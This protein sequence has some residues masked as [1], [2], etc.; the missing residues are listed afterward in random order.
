MS[1]TLKLTNLF[2]K[3]VSF[4]YLCAFISYLVQYDTL[5]SEHDGLE[6]IIIPLQKHYGTYKHHPTI[7]NNNYSIIKPP[8]TYTQWSQLPTLLSFMSYT[9]LSI[10]NNV[11]LLC[12]IG[13]LSSIYNCIR[14]YHH[15]NKSSTSNNVSN[16]NS[17]GVHP[18]LML[19]QWFIYLSFVKTI[20]RE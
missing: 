20:A 14:G 1:S 17:I 18:L 16:N 11:K 2:S 12:L 13:I 10:D 8:K 5:Y 15:N 7:T 19:L 6:P 9:G 4:C 3:L